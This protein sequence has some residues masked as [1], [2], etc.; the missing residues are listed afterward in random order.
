MLG[1]QLPASAWTGSCKA[2][3]QR[4]QENISCEEGVE[5]LE[6]APIWWRTS[7]HFGPGRAGPAAPGSPGMNPI[8]G[9]AAGRAPPPP[10]PHQGIRET[11]AGTGG[12]RPAADSAP[13]GPA[14]SK[15][16]QGVR[17][18]TEEHS[19]V[20]RPTQVSG[21][22]SC[23]SVEVP[24]PVPYGL[25]EAQPRAVQEPHLSP[26]PCSREAPSWAPASPEADRAP[27][28]RPP[29]EEDPQCSAA[30]APPPVVTAACIIPVPGLE[31]S[32]R[33][34]RF[35]LRPPPRQDL[36]SSPRSGPDALP[37]VAW[38]EGPDSPPRQR[39]AGDTGVE[40]GECASTTLPGSR[41]R[42]C[43]PRMLVGKPTAPPPPQAFPD[44][45]E[46]AGLLHLP[47]AGVAA[48]PPV[49]VALAPSTVPGSCSQGHRDRGRDCKG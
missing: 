41:E 5:R 36:Q 35:T 11:G 7:F 10:P 45:P 25:L 13:E 21:S 49:P 28:S 14:T 48:C 33:G 44:G 26:D 37:T 15:S 32:S 18:D 17:G 19:K 39:V 12:P 22:P 1:F 4:K 8:C 30:P 6:L 42:P 16:K 29:P 2:T 40:G 31:L 20:L 9:A 24:S 3:F 46:T 38:L 27:R 23:Q 43:L 34:E 47:R